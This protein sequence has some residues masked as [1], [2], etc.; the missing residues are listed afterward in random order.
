MKSQKPLNNRIDQYLKANPQ[1]KEA[2]N[3]F[4][5]SLEQYQKALESLSTQRTVTN[6]KDTNSNG[7]VAGN[8]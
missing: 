4:S 2:L 5:I 7:D 8:S 6:F 3:V 1:I